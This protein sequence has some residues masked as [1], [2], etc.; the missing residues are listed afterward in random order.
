MM[1]GTCT[2]AFTTTKHCGS[3]AAVAMPGRS[4]AYQRS[5]AARHGH[6]CLVAAKRLGYSV[7]GHGDSG[8]SIRV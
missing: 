5:R 6:R 3:V 1:G 7:L 2:A 4:I 8:D